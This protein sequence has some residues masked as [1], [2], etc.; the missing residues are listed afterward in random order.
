MNCFRLFAILLCAAAPPALNGCAS[1]SPSGSVVENVTPKPIR[2]AK[3]DVHFTD[4]TKIAGMNFTHINGAFGERMMPESVGSGAAF[5]DFDGDGYQDIFLVNSRDWTKSEIDAYKSGNNRQRAALVPKT[6]PQRRAIGALYRNNHN[7]TFTDVTRGSGLDSEMFGMGAAVG[8]YDNDGRAD[9]FVTGLNRNYLFHNQSANGQARFVEVAEK[10]GVRG[11][12]WSTS[13]CWFDYDKDGRLD[14]FV[15]HYI[16]WTPAKDVYASRDG[17]LKSYTGPLSY[18]AEANVLY[19][20]LGGGRFRDVS[21]SA[22]ISQTLGE[23]ARPL[24]G[25]SLGV[26]MCDYDEDGW[27]DLIVTNDQRPNFLFH[28]RG[29]KTFEEVAVETGIAYSESGQARAGMGVDSGDI[30]GSGRASIL[31]GNY[32][33]EMLGLYQNQS[34]VFTDTAPR[35]SVGRASLKFLT[36]GCNFL[37]V[38][39][40]G[41]LDILAVNGHVDDDERNLKSRGVTYRQRP[42][43]LEN[44]GKGRFRDIGAQSGAA[45]AQTVVGRGLAYADIDLDGDLDVLIT[46]NSGAPLLLRNDTENA[47]H[48][49]R[50]QLRGEK[51]NRDGIGARVIAQVGTQKLY[52]W[53]R[54]GSSYLSANELPLTLG[55]GQ[56]RSADITVEWPSGAKS[57]LKAVASGQV[58]AVSESKGITVRQP[59]ATAVDKK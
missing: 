44:E 19:R 39:N 31:I 38:N 28:N 1:S 29:G 50:L 40:D 8:D 20:N 15:C 43:L 21:Q 34:G 35:S 57:E 22:G 27:P 25:G 4:I 52:R 23:N 32:S 54:S 7:G 18:K 13:A 10:A 58:L 9:L 11:A 36:F 33:D 30:D 6:T 47:N 14:L 48:A 41:W 3:T 5:L 24:R 46:A 51:S 26:A 2:D 45:L 12:G 55:L 37:D 42:L 49:I 53:V 56:N 59:L 17:K 16:E